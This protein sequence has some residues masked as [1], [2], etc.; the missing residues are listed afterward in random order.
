MVL[1]QLV[2]VAMKPR[3]CYYLT[4]LIT[5]IAVQKMHKITPTTKIIQAVMYSQ[6][7]NLNQDDLASTGFFFSA[8]HM[9]MKYREGHTKT[10]KEPQKLPVI[11]KI[12]SS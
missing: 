6:L 10:I 9:A 4:S 3:Y 7:E 5:S 1:R 2:L 12:V 8:L 11:P